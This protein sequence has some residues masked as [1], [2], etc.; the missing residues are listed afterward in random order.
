MKVLHLVRRL[1][2]LLVFVLGDSKAQTLTEVLCSV[3]ERKLAVVQREQLDAHLRGWPAPDQQLIE[4]TGLPET[5]AF[6]ANGTV[7]ALTVGGRIALLN[8]AVAEFTQL[9]PYYLNLRPGDMATA[10]KVGALRPYMQE[11]FTP[12]PRVDAENFPVVLAAFARQVRHLKVLPWVASLRQRERSFNK[13]K[14]ETLEDGVPVLDPASDAIDWQQVQLDAGELDDND[15]V[16]TAVSAGDPYSL[17]I[18]SVSASGTYRITTYHNGPP[19]GEGDYELQSADCG[20]S[21]TFFSDARLSV[22]APGAGETVNGKVALVAR[23]ELGFLKE[24]S[25]DALPDSWNP[26]DA[27]FHVIAVSG[28]GGGEIE[29]SQTGPGIKAKLAWSNLVT[30]GDVQSSLGRSDSSRAVGTLGYSPLLRR[31]LYPLF[32]PSFSRGLDATGQDIPGALARAGKVNRPPAGDAVPL[33]Q[34]R[35]GLIFGIPLGVGLD[36][37]SSLGWLGISPGAYDFLTQGFDI[38]GPQPVDLFA[39]GVISPGFN[40]HAGYTEAD[41]GIRFDFAANLRF[42]GAAED[43]HVIYATGRGADHRG[44]ALPTAKPTN[45]QVSQSGWEE[46]SILTAWDLPRIRQVVGRDLIADVS[47]QGHYK[48]TVTI[49]RRPVTA[50]PVDRTPGQLVSLAGLEPLRTLVFGNPNNLNDDIFPASAEAVTI[51]DGESA[52]YSVIRSSLAKDSGNIVF[53]GPSVERTVS[54]TLGSE[55]QFGATVAT[56][57]DGVAQESTTITGDEHWRWWKYRQP[58]RLV[59]SAAGETRTHIITSDGSPG[60]RGGLFPRTLT[61]TGGSE[62]DSSFAWDVNGVLSATEQGLWT[63]TTSP[64]GTS[65]L[66]TVLKFNDSVWETAWTEWGAGGRKVKVH[67]APDGLPASMGGDSVN[68]N[69]TEYGDCTETGFPGLP[70]VIRNKDTT[71]KTFAWTNQ[72]DGAGQVVT[73]SGLM[74]QGAVTR[75][76]RITRSWSSRGFVVSSSTELLLSGSLDIGGAAVPAGKFTS[77]GAPTEWKDDFSPLKSVFTHDGQF[78]RLATVTHPLG[79]Q[80]VFSNLDS[81]GRARTVEANGITASHTYTAL[82]VESTYEGTDIGEESES[83]TTRDALGRLTTSNTTWNGVTDSLALT[84]GAGSVDISQTSGTYG[85]HS[86][87]VRQEDG[88]LASVSGPTLAFGGTSGNALSVSNGLLVTRSKIQNAPFT[89]METHTD[90]WGRVRKVVKPSAAGARSAT[91]TVAY[92]NPDAALQRTRV[93]E[94]SGRRFITESDPY[95]SSGSIYRSGID[96]DS[97]G[98][99]GGVSDRYIQS[100]TTVANGKV[101]TVLKQTKPLSASLRDVLRT[102]LTPSSG[103]AVTKINANEET[104]TSTPNYANKTVTTISTKGWSHTTSINNLGLA[105]S[106]TLSGTGIPATALNPTWRADGSLADVSLTIGGETH[107]ASFNNDGT[108]ASLTI[109]GRGNILD[110][111]SIS[112][113]VE[114]LTVDGITTTRKLDGTEASTSG[115]EVPGKTETLAVNGNG[116]KHTTTPAVGS[117]T[118]VAFNAAG[119]ATVKNYAAG[120]GESYGYTNELLTSVSLARGGGI[121]Y[122][123]SRNGA[124]DLVSAVWPAVASGPFSI[125]M[126]AE[127]Y[128]TDRAGGIDA[129]VDA[130]GTRTFSYQ[131]GR[132]ASSNYTAGLLRG[133]QTIRNHDTSG[134]HTGILLK[135]D[136]ATIHSTVKAPNGASDQITGLASGGITAT[137]QRDGAGRITGYVWS[138]GTGNTV[139]QTWQRGAGGRIEFAGSDVPGAPTFDYLLNPNVPTESFDARNRRLKCATAGGTWTYTY[140]ISGQLSSATHPTLG[141]FTYAFD[142]IG[143]RTDMGAANTTNLLNQSTAWTNSQPKKL[144]LSAHPDARV[145]FNGT[146]IQN[147]PGSHEVTLGTPGATGQWI[148]WHT[149]AVLEGQGEGAGSPPANA[150]ASPD[151]KAAQSGAVW[152]PPAQETLAYDAAGNRQGNT[153]WDYGWDAKNQLVRARTKNHGSAAHAYDLTFTHD[154]EGRRVQ[155]HVVEYQHGAVVSEKIITFVWD[156]WDLVYERQQL[157]SGLTTIERRYLWG[158]D[159]ADGAAGGAGGLLLIQETKGNNTQK[160]IPL[161]DGTGHVT[162]LTNLNKDLLASYAYG[163]FGEKISATGPLANS[164][165]W[166]WATKYFDE[167]TGLYY[168]GKRYLDPVTGQWLSRELLGE[169]ESL[170]LYS[171]CHNDP[172]NRVDVLGLAEVPFDMEEKRRLGELFAAARELEMDILLRR[173]EATM[174]EAELHERQQLRLN[175]F[176]NKEYEMFVAERQSGQ[177]EIKPDPSRPIQETAALC[178]G[179]ATN[180]V[181]AGLNTVFI[182]PVGAETFALKWLGICG[183]VIAKEARVS[184]LL[185]STASGVSRMQLLTAFG[186]E[187]QFSAQVARSDAAFMQT[188]NAQE[189]LRLSAGVEDGV[190]GGMKS[191]GDSLLG[192]LGPAHLNNTDELASIM[193]DLRRHGVAIDYRAGQY[194]YGP[195]AGEAGNLVIDRN[196]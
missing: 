161:Y 6:P 75:G 126:L 134:R 25:F 164:N 193:A 108:L 80:T 81:I 174:N 106:N 111:H 162:A 168:F 172:V 7:D 190:K 89:Y 113:G 143:R 83:T 191:G 152:M 84:Y 9:A 97:D 127:G 19:D 163:P 141:T 88:T 166:R 30:N 125:P 102:E 46:Q 181:N 165:P 169:S 133:Y 182:S 170:N 149:L 153:Q 37:D 8:Q 157:P 21:T 3:Q 107:S 42:V 167:E 4:W 72:A 53:T 116:F 158:P 121:A 145:W 69:E 173:N 48:F 91:T 118:D 150:L 1:I 92:S 59:H 109:P 5:T 136:G 98:T 156:G 160:I 47:M 44:A 137:P 139:T 65:A 189:L 130:S 103:V 18:E 175:Y 61:S 135:R 144:T 56:S 114:T 100:I 105:T 31:I 14:W 129:L 104:I 34:P 140:G 179:G 60:C 12:L 90:A 17:G 99:L 40:S 50:M 96:V 101:V 11:D 120:A 131:N 66:K 132:L 185:G 13:S 76:E 78:S 192:S 178:V 196:A 112:G 70:R 154:A 39:Y 49:Y 23:T 15:P 52:T 10:S 51:A 146:E 177:P 128:H 87:E 171:Y 176:L 22:A 142:A 32:I 35:P 62:P 85:T 188:A 86:A 77:W 138:D 194:A 73:E 36:G 68:W 55:G 95:N 155:K 20:Q 148:E 27:S 67:T 41:L 159:I 45:T 117:Q 74:D 122:G 26:T 119:A 183:S 186:K 195:R 29:L 38:W 16:W 24:D 71:G 147:F 82:N 180:E 151:A 64:E 54:L 63:A 58:E 28:V 124:K 110:G 187:L 57:L 2:P 79:L 33:L 43:F 115:G 94:P 184:A 123:Y 93:T